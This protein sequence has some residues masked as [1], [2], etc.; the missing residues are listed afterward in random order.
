MKRRY[1]GGLECYYC[2]PIGMYVVHGWDHEDD[3]GRGFGKPVELAHFDDEDEA[4]SYMLRVTVPDAGK[5]ASVK[6]L[7]AA[8]LALET[9]KFPV[10][11][12]KAK[13][14]LIEAIKFA[15]GR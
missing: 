4:F 3:R 13:D 5:S 8:R 10:G 1:R 12:M 11:A 15:E 14:A 7:N 9:C 6:L 2:E